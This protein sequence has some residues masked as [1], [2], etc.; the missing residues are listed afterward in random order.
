MEYGH[1]NATLISLVKQKNF[2]LFIE[3]HRERVAMEYDIYVTLM[4]ILSPS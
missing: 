2:Y 3:V 1:E 4:L